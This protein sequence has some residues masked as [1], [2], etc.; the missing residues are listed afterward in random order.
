MLRSRSSLSGMNKT[1]LFGENALVP[2][3]GSSSLPCTTI[4]TFLARRY[5]GSSEEIEDTTFNFENPSFADITA[6][7]SGPIISLSRS[8]SKLQAE[9][10]DSQSISVD[11][12]SKPSASNI[13]LSTSADKGIFSLSFQASRE[14]IPYVPPI[15]S[16]GER[17]CNDISDQLPP[18][19]IGSYNIIATLGNGT[20]GE[21]ILASPKESSSSDLYAI[22]ILRGVEERDVVREVSILELICEWSGSQKAYDVGVRFLQKLQEAFENEDVHFLV[23]EY[24]PATL[25]D[26]EVASYFR[27]T[28]DKHSRLSTSVSLPVAFDRCLTSTTSLEETVQSVR[29]LIAEIGLG[30]AFLHARGFIHQ[31]IKPANILLSYAGHVVIGDFG[32]TSKMPFVPS[33]HDRQSSG[34]EIGHFAPVV[35]DA[36]DFVTFTPLYAA[37]EMKECNCNGQVIY[38]HHSDWWSL[39][40]LLHELVTGTVPFQ[41]LASSKLILDGRRSEGDRSL[42]FGDL[43]TLSD[44]LKDKN[45]TWYP[46]LDHFLRSLLS[47]NP[48]DRLSW[49]DV[50][51][52][53]FLIPLRGLWQDIADLKH[54]PCPI[55]P[56]LRCHDEIL[57]LMED[58]DDIHGVKPISITLSSQD[59]LYDG[60]PVTAHAASFKSGDFFP[61]SSSLPLSPMETWKLYQPP[62]THDSDSDG[63]SVPQVL[64]SSASIWACGDIH[65]TSISDSELHDS[66]CDVYSRPTFDASST[67]DEMK[68]TVATPYLPSLFSSTPVFDFDYQQHLG[69]RGSSYSPGTSPVVCGDLIALEDITWSLIEAMEYRDQVSCE[70]QQRGRCTSGRKKIL[71]IFR[72][73]LRRLFTR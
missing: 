27:L 26:P 1:S 48:E 19:V 10:T 46:A 37:P 47:H 38:D 73:I 5:Y 32:A 8:M 64:P 2:L 17:E 61:P 7:I 34:V 66:G 6:Y 56:T 65:N 41:K 9:L 55:L 63:S 29:L 30:L 11:V 51:E 72:R 4:S 70:E 62:C 40:I 68:Y 18:R 22:K 71:G 49:P 50:K 69:L 35:L 20:H 57:S 45:V 12:V 3:Q 39:G 14:H 42:T 23:L 15:I 60:F 59:N 24:H 52:H 21:V 67:V 33:G 31:D 28:N 58:R 53:D 13:R 43:E 25:S 44:Q 36:D 16:S 54:P